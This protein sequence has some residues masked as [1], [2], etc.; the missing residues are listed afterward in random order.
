MKP[1][2]GFANCSRNP[3][4]AEFVSRQPP[5]ALDRYP[6]GPAAAGSLTP[7]ALHGVRNKGQATPTRDMDTARE[8]MRDWI[9]RNE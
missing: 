3:E 8:R 7:V 5:A 4:E 9:K 1:P 6:R 2:A